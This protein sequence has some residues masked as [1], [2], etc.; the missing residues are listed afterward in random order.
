MMYLIKK[1]LWFQTDI[2]LN[3]ALRRS[4][5]DSEKPSDELKPINLE[6][7]LM[8]I[9]VEKVQMPVESKDDKETQPSKKKKIIGPNTDK[10]QNI[11]NI[12]KLHLITMQESLKLLDRRLKNMMLLTQHCTRE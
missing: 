3:M 7:E 10:Q 2:Q 1:N 5:R 6:S 11:R 12:S 9:E 4:Q 8:T